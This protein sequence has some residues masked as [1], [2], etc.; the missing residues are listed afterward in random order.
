M[1]PMVTSTA[2][3]VGMGDRVVDP[4][5]AAHRVTQDVNGFQAERIDEAHH[6]IQ[7]GDHG[8]AA[9]IV[10]DTESGK[11]QDQAAEEVGKC[12]H[13]PRK[14]RQPV[15]PGPDPCSSSN[16]GPSIGRLRDN[17]ELLRRW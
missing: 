2:H 14:F 17:A 1:P 12:A 5:A 11:L 7:R 4:D 8:V 16:T 13:T 3:P 15:T 9:E 6:R 10:A